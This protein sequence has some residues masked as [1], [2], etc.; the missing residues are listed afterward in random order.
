[1]G[2]GSS[3][4][5]GGNQPGREDT[6]WSTDMSWKN[7]G[8]MSIKEQ[9]QGPQGAE[10]KIP[11]QVSL[12]GLGKSRCPMCMELFKVPRILPCLHTFCTACLEE[13]EPFSVLMLRTPDSEK[14]SERPWLWDKQPQ[15][16][17]PQLSILCPVCDTE[18]DLP[19]GGVKALTIDHLAINKVL[20]QNLQ[21]DRPCLVCD[22]CSDREV[23]SR[24]LTCRVNLCQFCSQAHRRQKKTAFHSIMPLKDLKGYNQIGKAIVCSI[25]PPEELNL[26]CEQCDQPVCRDCVL[27]DHREHTYDLVSNVIYKHGNSIRDLLKS[28]QPHMG[29]LERALI[30]IEGVGNALRSRMDALS[31]DVREFCDG[32]IMAIREHRDQLLKQ[33][34]DVRIQKEN[35]LH[36]QKLQVEQ[37]LADLR[38]GVEFTEHLLNNGTDLEIL[39]T[40]KVVVNRLKKLKK[41]DYSIGPGLDD[42]I[43]FSPQEKAGQYGGYEVFGAILTKGVD[44]SKCILQG[45]DIQKVCEKQKVTL[46]LLCR[47]ILGEHMG[48][49]G[50]HI[51]VN[52]IHK[53]KDCVLKTMVQ[54]NNNGT[55]T[56]SFSPEELGLYTVCIFVKGQHIQGSPYTMTVRRRF[57]QHQGV[58]HCCS[59][60]SSGGQKNARCA[61]GG[62]MAGGYQGC[63][64]GHKG[65]PGRRHWSC[66]GGTEENS[67]C[68]GEIPQRSLVRT[69][70]L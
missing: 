6:G 14:T 16:L 47:D 35:S 5:A 66:C 31:S 41:T 18:V 27:G 45:E 9:E 24:C 38:T 34:E 13:L 17:E 70:A 46:T 23:D 39:V 49:G 33:L 68:L 44:P 62:T 40:K 29:T 12:G 51:R 69:V 61:C 64:H 19:P 36:L 56:I 37:L 26:F 22:L 10:A 21:E 52:V 48:R 58:F 54:D 55:Y 67:E 1:M 32:Y 63:G 2:E 30:Q 43:C 65:H 11:S 57:R 42:G 60:C 28:T 59:F 20:L 25:H 8:E 7:L 50:E 53:N 15:H 3:S 4:G